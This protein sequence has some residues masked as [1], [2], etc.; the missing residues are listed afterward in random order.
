M[1]NSL[2]FELI[3]YVFPSEV[4]DYFSLVEIKEEKKDA[5]T[6]I[7]HLCLDE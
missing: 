4:V 3:K 1:Q 7:L 6:T 2:E 5:D